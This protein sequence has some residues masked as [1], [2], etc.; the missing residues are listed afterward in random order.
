MPFTQSEQDSILEQ[1]KAAAL[2]DLEALLRPEADTCEAAL[3]ELANKWW[4]VFQERGENYSRFR[5]HAGA[6]YRCVLDRMVQI[7]DA[8]E[9]GD[10][11][12]EHFR[13]FARVLMR[14]VPRR[15][16]AMFFLG[17]HDFQAGYLKAELECDAEGGTAQEDRAGRLTALRRALEL[18]GDA[19]VST[20][21]L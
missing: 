16:W 3:R 13:R 21:W 17:W 19:A 10:L 11:A 20:D 1:H 15:Y 18:E 5:A 9:G 4:A 12:R 7:V 6:V 14:N 8:G 2:A